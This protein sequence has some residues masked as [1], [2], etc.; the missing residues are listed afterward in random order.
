MEGCG[1]GEEAAAAKLQADLEAA[2]AERRFGAI[3]LGVE[4]SD[5]ASLEAL[6]RNYRVVDRLDGR[7]GGRLEGQPGGGAA[8]LPA[9]GAPIGP[10]LW[11]EPR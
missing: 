5:W 7:L 10:R 9:T 1:R 3:V 11:L 4:L 8:L 6:T 2:L